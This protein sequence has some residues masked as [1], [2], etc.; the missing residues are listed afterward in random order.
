MVPGI[1]F[2]T[3]NQYGDEGPSMFSV[4]LEKSDAAWRI[5]NKLPQ[6]AND[7]VRALL[8]S[9]PDCRDP[10]SGILAGVRIRAC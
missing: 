9:R 7:I 1:N 2:S 4:M 10:V 3:F 5:T 8:H 6:S